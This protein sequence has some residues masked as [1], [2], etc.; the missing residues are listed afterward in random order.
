MLYRL[1]VLDL[2][3]DVYLEPESWNHYG[4]FF[5]AHFLID[6]HHKL[7]AAALAQRPIGFLSFISNSLS[8]VNRINSAGDWKG[9]WSSDFDLN[10]FLAQPRES[11]D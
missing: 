4:A 5:L 2:H 8:A 9:D 3:Y 10:S 6:G 7:H 1:S 11:V